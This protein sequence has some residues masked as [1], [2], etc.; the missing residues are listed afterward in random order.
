MRK[1]KTGKVLKPVMTLFYML[2]ITSVVFSSTGVFYTKHF[3][4]S[5][6][7][8]LRILETIV[9][10]E[11]C[12]CKAE[13]YNAN[14]FLITIAAEDCCSEFDHYAKA[15]FQ[16]EKVIPAKYLINLPVS[17]IFVESGTQEAIAEISGLSFCNPPPPPNLSGQELVIHFHC[18]RIPLS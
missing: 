7:T 1:P 6:Q 18:L 3:C 8:G 4:H 9:I 10:S 13:A 14:G 15:D 11:K 17:N 12:N 16:S 5:N 2:I